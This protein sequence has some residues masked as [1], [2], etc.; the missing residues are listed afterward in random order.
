MLHVACKTEASKT[1]TLNVLT[2]LSRAE[3]TTAPING[4]RVVSTILGREDLYMQ[5][6]LDLLTM[7][8]RMKAMR[9]RLVGA[10]RELRTPGSWD[11]ILTDV[12]FM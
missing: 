3:I 1:K 5:W 2:Q 6:L 4:A 10:L 8:N 11:H 7:S 12:S 9:Q